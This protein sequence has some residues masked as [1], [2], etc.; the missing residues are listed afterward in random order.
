[1]FCKY[2]GSRN[3]DDAEYCCTCG[4]QIA[5]TESRPAEPA[6]Q[7]PRLPITTPK[8]VQALPYGWGKFF[9][10]FSGFFCFVGVL[11]GLFVASQGRYLLSVG[12]LIIAI[13]LAFQ[14]WGFAQGSDSD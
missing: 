3:P 8:A 14:A 4:R 13:L 1:M 12:T 9:S 11:M 2:C 6:Q 7:I 10:V 5:K